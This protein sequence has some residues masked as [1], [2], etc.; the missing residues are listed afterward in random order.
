MPVSVKIE[1][2]DAV[3][4]FTK[5]ITIRLPRESNK[6]NEKLAKNTQNQAK[7]LLRSRYSKKRTVQPTG[8][9]SSSII[10]YQ[11]RPTEWR[12]RMGNLP[13]ALVQ[14]YGHVWSGR[15]FIPK[16]GKG[17]TGEGFSVPD[18][19]SFIAVQG[20]WFMRDAIEDTVQKSDK[21]IEETVKEVLR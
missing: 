18:P 5:Q 8:K 9:L 4:N 14:E 16:A 15:R 12:V 17:H 20:K 1:G 11:Q 10:A 3:I 21:M 2:L 13:Y 7:L 6:L 19:S